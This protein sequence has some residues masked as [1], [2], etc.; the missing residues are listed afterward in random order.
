M[1]AQTFE[2]IKIALSKKSRQTREEY[3]IAEKMYYKRDPDEQWKRP[4][5][6][7]GQ[8]ELLVFLRHG[9]QIIK[10]HACRVQPVKSTSPIIP[11]NEKRD[12]NIEQVHKDKNSRSISES[13]SDSEM[14]N[15]KIPKPPSNKSNL[16]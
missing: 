7:V 11:E 6:V 13:D 8:D 14:D 4:V 10:A 9:S 3:D 15:N 12:K 16:S 1:K 5:H 2:K